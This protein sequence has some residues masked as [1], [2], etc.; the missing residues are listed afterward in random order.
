MLDTS[1]ASLWHWRQRDDLT[2]AKLAI[3]YWQP[4]RVHALLGSAAESARY[5][6]LSLDSASEPDTPVFHKAYAFRPSRAASIAHDEPQTS[7]YLGQARAL[8]QQLADADDRKMLLDDLGSI[9]P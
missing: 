4:S 6:K 7:E 9:R 5:A 8:A 3:A 2:P 1:H